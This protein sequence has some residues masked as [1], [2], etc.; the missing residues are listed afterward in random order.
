MAVDTLGAG[1]RILIA[2][3]QHDVLE[4]LELLL[5]RKGFNVAAAS[6]PAALLR[7]L[8]NEEFDAL[9]MDLNYARDTTSGREGLEL[10]PLIRDIDDILP[11]V[12]M[13]AW[14]SIESAV[15]A[16]RGGARD[17]IEKPWDNTRLLATLQ[18]NVELAQALRTSRRLRGENRLLRGSDIPTFIAESPVMQP[19]KSLMQ[20]VGPSDANVLIT[21][22]HG[23]G[24]E[25]V[26]RWLH[27][28]SSRA[29][30]AFVAVNIGGLAENVRE[31]E[32]FGHVRG[33]FT[34]AKSD[35]VGLFELA[36]RGTLFLDEIANTPASLQATLLRVIESG[37]FQ[38][39]GASRARTT[40]AR[41]L[42]ATNAML[43]KEVSDGRF[44][45]DLLFRLNTVEIHLPSLRERKEDIAL[46]AGHFLGQHTERYGKP[47]V[48]FAGEAM[49]VLLAH[50]WPG[51]IRELDHTVERA[52]LM[53][54]SDVIRTKDLGL[55]SD[56]YGETPL[57]ECT[58]R[59]IEDYYV[60][61]ALQ[62]SGGNVSAAAKS[63]GISR[64]SLYR[65]LQGDT[66]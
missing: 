46:L 55:R 64:A 56:R 28:A 22:E 23:T 38:R 37:E 13:T 32:L 40:D 26:A 59:E 48:E 7:A 11:V 57:E 24:K 66:P 12:V 53:C 6:S 52:V 8:K 63:L 35:R 17:Y 51:N 43:E 50:S 20:R 15:E 36:D 4:S 49:Q 47:N 54:D 3:D 58:L 16:M 27:A 61:A 65:R 29:T 41:I 62:R 21:G 44:R 2:D 1:G 39:V 33:A 42:S 45:E 10:L 34:D 14:G 9:L 5:T 25:V 19:V 30:E 18:T 31:S 60:H